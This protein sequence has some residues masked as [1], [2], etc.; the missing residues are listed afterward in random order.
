MK[1]VFKC[2]FPLQV[3][4]IFPKLMSFI[5]KKV[6]QRAVIQTA[7][8]HACI[9]VYGVRWSPLSGGVSRL[10]DS[11]KS[12]MPATCQHQVIAFKLLIQIKA[13]DKVWAVSYL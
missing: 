9:S 7:L 1:N 6:N 4:C 2:P 11:K 3:I 12:I 5:K 10:A 13:L 8:P